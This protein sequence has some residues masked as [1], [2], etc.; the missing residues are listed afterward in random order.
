MPKAEIPK[1][2]NPKPVEPKWYDLWLRNGIFYA[3]A[4]SP[5][6]PFS[7]VIPPP[8]V[9]DVLHLGHG[10]NNT[11]QD[12][13]IRWKR[14][15][16]YEAM[17]L[18]GTDHA[19]IA[20]QVIIEKKLANEGKTKWDLGREKF[21]Q[22][23]WEW[24][25]KNG[26]YI[27]NQLKKIG[28]SCDWSRTRFTLD[29]MLSNAVLEVFIRLYN[30]GLIYKGKYIINWCPRCM[31][32]LS[33]DETVREEIAGNLWYIKY[34]IK[35]SKG[36]LTVATTR[37]E[38]M[39]GDTALAV[40]PK[41]KRYKKYV[42]KTAVLPVIGRELPII[43]DSYVDQDF[44]TG[45]VKVTPAHDKN[46]FEIS[47]RH[48]LEKVVVI[49]PDGSMSENA[50]K[51]KGM[52]RYECRK[53]LL[54]KLK[55]EKLL[56]KI[57][58]YQ[59]PVSKC[60]RCD[61]IIEPYLSEQW[62]VKMQPLAQPAIK[63]YQ[64]GKLKF[65]PE[66]WGKVYLH[67]LENIHDWCISRQL[68][69]G[70]RIPVWYCKDCSEINVSKA[71]PASCKKCR[72]TDLEQDPDVLD[73]W[74]SS[75]L[76]PFSTLGW[77]EN[78]L[79]LKTFYPTKALFTGPD[80][81]FL[82][83]ARM[84]MAGLEFRQEVPFSD[85]YIH[86]TV[87][88]AQGVKMSKSLGNG[89]DPLDIIREYGTDALR[90][91]I[92]L[93]A[94]D[95][96]DPCISFNS[97]EQG[98][99][100]ANKL[101]N[102]SRLVMLSLGEFIPKPDLLESIASENLTLADKWILSRLN[103]TISEVTKR[104]SVYQFNSAAKI[105]YD[106]TWHDFCDWYLE[107]AKSRFA[108]SNSATD[109]LLAQK[110]SVGVLEIILKLLHPFIPFVTEE[111]WHL[112]FPAQEN[113]TIGL[114]SWPTVQE[115]FLDESAEKIM[116]NLQEIIVNIRNIKSEINLHPSKKPAVLLKVDD[117]GVKEGLLKHQNYILELAKVEKIEIGKVKKPENS[118]I[119]VSKD[120]EIYVPLAGLVDLDEEKGRLEK[121]IEKLKSLLEK[122]KE[123]LSDKNFLSKAP[124]EIIEK[125]KAKKEDWQM[126]LKKLQENLKSLISK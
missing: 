49:N 7:V 103:K 10:L 118:A 60:Y 4:D 65:Y 27:L 34:P 77:P 61:T 92:V 112:L 73:T 14:M 111:I 91:S 113:K 31:T 96:Q 39:L 45:V 126:R 24:K 83:V 47:K 67:W 46:D 6:E 69:W 85:V 55:K 30:K 84:V 106:F 80:I 18:P 63:V 58:P 22:L 100:F 87:R 59:V 36:F 5:K 32:S 48:N 68:W 79:D 72:S 29:E 26:E 11:L 120:I 44:G 51:Y 117:N 124:A 86:G 62:F 28:C 54:E 116:G 42:G 107:T 95:G 115:Q 33:D 38:T 71:P 97:F 109:C 78:S 20:T 101:W 82:W 41:D 1:Q 114:E 64:E 56:E 16:G 53:K 43:E 17:W 35:N 19:G 125:E 75:W 98:R 13:L 104:L 66:H 40:N 37:P 12:I 52:D 21:I 93:A 76:W 89:I 57:A 2:Y 108:S 81:I 88:D 23:V 3:K 122:N 105:I 90:Y 102:A 9:T 15:Q 74:F 94:P 110:I 70:H 50:G 25:E 121:E 123:R 119:R 8:N 99:N